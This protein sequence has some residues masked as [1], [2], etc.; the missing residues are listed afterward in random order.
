MVVSREY[1]YLYV[2]IG[3]CCQV[4][5]LAQLDEGNARLTPQMFSRA[6]ALLTQDARTS[7]V[8]GLSALQLC[9]VREAA[10][11]HTYSVLSY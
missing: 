5:C 3:L 6:E 10:P 8:R 9:L 1:Y 4:M 11:Y 7:T 2:I